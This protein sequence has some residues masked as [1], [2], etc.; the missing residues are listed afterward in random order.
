MGGMEHLAHVQSAIEAASLALENPSTRSQAEAQ[1]LEFRSRPLPFAACQH[2]LLHST[3]PAAQFQA[4]LALRHAALLGWPRLDTG[5]RLDLVRFLL[6][7]ALRRAHD[8]H[9][10]LRHQCGAIAAQ[11][12][13]RGHLNKDWGDLAL[14]SIV[15][16]IVT[17]ADSAP[18]MYLEFVDAK[19][20]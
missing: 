9:R 18:G 16:G 10:L 14:P 7:Q 20:G 19:L 15:H 4:L 1:L 17:K 6:D 3:I 8:P 5:I 13:K 2:V 12:M 11:L